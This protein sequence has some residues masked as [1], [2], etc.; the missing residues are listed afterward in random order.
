MLSFKCVHLPDVTCSWPMLLGGDG[1]EVR[2][3]HPIRI[4]GP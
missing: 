2:E 3:H 4:G 1:D